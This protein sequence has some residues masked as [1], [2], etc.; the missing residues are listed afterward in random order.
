MKALLLLLLLSACAGN[1]R[2]SCRLEQVADVPLQVFGNVPVLP[3][4]INGRRAWLVLDT[5]SDRTVLTR[6]AAARVGVP[7]GEGVQR[8]GAAG[9]RAELG[10]AVMDTLSLSGMELHAVR[11]LLADAPR[12]PL[13]G[14]LGLD[15]LVGFEVELDLP[16]R[17]AVFYRARTCLDAR[18]AWA[19]VPLA[20]QQQAGSGHVFVPVELDGQ[21]LRGLLDTG[22]S[23]TTLS[24]QA[25]EDVGVTRRALALLPGTR[26]QAINAEGVVVRRAVFRALR[27]GPDLIERP[28]LAITDLPPF[29]GDML[30]GSDY[31]GTRRVWFALALGRVWV[32]GQ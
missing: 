11:A 5:G 6:A 8:V 18:P 32:E 12:P 23:R 24:V 1:P 22:A 29:A 13:D 31:L 15:V 25:A 16:H 9:G 21:P 7:A 14:V 4:E 3:L 30:V 17:H 28:A 19:G 20:A 10:V 2:D 26:G 27:I